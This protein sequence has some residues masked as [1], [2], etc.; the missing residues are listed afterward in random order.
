[1]KKIN[2]V[3][4]AG[5]AVATMG[6]GMPGVTVLP[7]ATKTDNTIQAPTKKSMPV[8]VQTQQQQINILPGGHID[9]KPYNAGTP[10]KQYG[11]YLQ[12]MGKQKWVKSK[13]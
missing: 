12:R 7:T 5:L 4:A 11:Q 1:M 13:K 9:Y 3:L 10:P 8:Q 2:Q 6:V